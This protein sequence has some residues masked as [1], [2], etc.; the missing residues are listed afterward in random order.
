MSNNPYKKNVLKNENKLYKIQFEKE[1]DIITNNCYWNFNPCCRDTII[2]YFKKIGWYLF[3][4]LKVIELYYF[5]R[6]RGQFYLAK[7]RVSMLLENL[8]FQGS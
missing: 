5:F 3:G 2:D 6:W 7:K 1:K 4:F 8:I